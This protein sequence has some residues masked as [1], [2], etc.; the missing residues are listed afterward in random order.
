MCRQEGQEHHCYGRKCG[1]VVCRRTPQ[2]TE[3]VEFCGIILL[4]LLIKVLDYGHKIG[5][6]RPREPDEKS[7]PAKSTY[8][9]SFR[10]RHVAKFALTYSRSTTTHSA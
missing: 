9:L 1:G 3:Y 6:K 2:S 4:Y 8:Y 7:E 5:G 10:N